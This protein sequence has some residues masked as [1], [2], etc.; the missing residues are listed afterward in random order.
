[1]SEHKPER[2]GSGRWQKGQSGNPRGRPRVELERICH[3][4]D[5]C[6][7]ESPRI[8]RK[9]VEL[10]LDGDTTAARL[11]LNSAVLP[12]KE[13]GY[14]EERCQQLEERVRELGAQLE[15]RPMS[16]VR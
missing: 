2:D 5:I 9:M 1:M 11:I 8:S 13:S 15:A 12:L 14:Y 10:A 6:E 7:K 3:I 4:R 16:V